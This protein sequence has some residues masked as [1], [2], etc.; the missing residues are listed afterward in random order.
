MARKVAAIPARHRDEG[1]WYY[2]DVDDNQDTWRRYVQLR[3]KEDRSD[4]E[5]RALDALEKEVDGLFSVKIGP[6]SHEEYSRIEG[7]ARKKA[8][9]VKVDQRKQEV[10]F[11]GDPLAMGEAVMFE[12]CE[13]RIFE[14]RNYLATEAE[15][16]AD[17]A[18]LLDAA[19]EIVTK[20]KAITKG[21][22]LVK[23]IRTEA[24][25]DEKRVLDDIF[26]AIKHRSHLSRGEKKTFPAR[27]SS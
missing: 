14:V 5:E 4:D 1:V 12:V 10:H 26:A 13:K 3:T 8:L 2:P 23:F 19:G 16:D 18:P 22:E 24:E 27:R 7:A 25:L 9:D 17:G 11:A 15:L 21:V 6:Y 20:T